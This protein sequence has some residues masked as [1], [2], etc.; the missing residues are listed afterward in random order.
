MLKDIEELKKM[1]GDK[2]ECST[3]DEEIDRLKNLI[4]QLASSGTEIKAPI[5]QT[6]PSLSSKDLNDLREALKK[7]AEIEQKLKDL[8][9]DGILKRLSVLEAD[10]IN[11]KTDISKVD[12]EAKRLEH[13]K[14]DK[15]NVEAELKKIQIEL[16]KLNDWC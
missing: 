15:K 5:V 6:G 8:S 11:A 16:Q 3:F 9:L 13:D 7:I 10:M 1:M 2:V 4:N 12:M 14:V